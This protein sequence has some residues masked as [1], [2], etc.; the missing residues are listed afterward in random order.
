MNLNS[1]GSPLAA[2]AVGGLAARSIPGAFLFGVGLA[3]L[4][5]VWPI[6]FPYKATEREAEVVD[7][8]PL[9]EPV[10]S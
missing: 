3:V 10:E 5:G 2:A 1:A 8:E 6:V 9:V 4:A 7:F